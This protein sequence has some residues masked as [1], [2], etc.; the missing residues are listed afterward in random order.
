MPSHKVIYDRDACVGAFS[1]VAASPDFWSYTDD[2]KADLKS[3]SYNVEKKR[4][5]LLIEEKDL[6]EHKAA[7]DV[8]PVV[9]IVIEKIEE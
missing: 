9:A 7:A 5:E 2:G 4:W 3:A 6:E 8:C 1:C